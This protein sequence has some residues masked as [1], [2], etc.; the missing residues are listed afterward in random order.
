MR[1]CKFLNQNSEGLPI[2]KDENSSLVSQLIGDGPAPLPTSG[3]SKKNEFRP[4]H[5]PRKQYV[6]REQWLRE[7]ESLISDLKGGVRGGVLRYLT[8]P[9]EDLL[10]IR[11]LAQKIC[12]N[13]E[14]KFYYLGFSHVPLEAHE[15]IDSSAFSIKRMNCIDRSSSIVPDDIRQ[16]GKHKSMAAGLL[17]KEAAF[18]VVNLD[19]CDSLASIKKRDTIPSYFDALGALLNKQSRTTEGS[20]LL[21]TTRMDE[22]CVDEGDYRKLRERVCALCEE[23]PAYKNE[24]IS[25]W[26]LDSALSIEDLLLGLTFQ[27][28]YMLGLAQWV[29]DQATKHHLFVAVKSFNSYRVG[30]RD[31]EDNLVSIAI[32]L[33]PNLGL[34]PDEAG[35]INDKG[36]AADAQDRKNM[37][38]TKVPAKVSKRKRVDEILKANVEALQ[39]CIDEMAELMG[40][41]GYS[42]EEY[43]AWA[44]SE[45]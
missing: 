25:Q 34:I 8:L 13:H 38:I 2:L 23:T 31:P 27:E 12:S 11:Y 21:L 24:I 26:N 1:F 14:L 17:E 7:V 6:R 10:D 41:S 18:H 19:L 39:E 33:K 30:E 20:L 9:G 43:R 29:I 3:T 36:A 37:A 16:I 15:T 28:L 22:E 42:V 5:R 32:R 4:W 35:L 45:S 40:A 44:Q